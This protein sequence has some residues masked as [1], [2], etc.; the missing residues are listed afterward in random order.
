MSANPLASIA[1]YE[2]LIYSLPDAFPCIQTTHPHHKHIPPGI[3]HHRVPAPGLS[4]DSPY[5][6]F[7]I[8]EIERTFLRV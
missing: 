6:P 4:F 2:T 3:K 5:L 8:R 1:D 7:L